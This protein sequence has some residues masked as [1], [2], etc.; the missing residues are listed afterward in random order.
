MPKEGIVSIKTRSSLKRKKEQ[1]ISNAPIKKAR[2]E[3]MKQLATKF[4]KSKLNKDKV[5]YFNEF[6]KVQKDIYP[7]LK[8]ESL[9]WHIRASEVTK[10]TA[11]KDT[12]NLPENN[13]NT[14]H[15]FNINQSQV[16]TL[17]DNDGCKIK[18]RIFFLVLWGAGV[19]SF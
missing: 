12:T 16:R 17:P 10:T 7:W 1:L 13:Q 3:M 15:S 18:Y 11:M 9:R 14:L 6:Y 8:K 2:I 5:T 19:Q 4:K